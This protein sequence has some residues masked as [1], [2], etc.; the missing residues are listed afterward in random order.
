MPQIRERTEISDLRDLRQ[1][2]EEVR[3]SG[4]PRLLVVGADEIAMLVPV[5]S[6]ATSDDGTTRSK[7]DEDRDVQ[8]FLSAAGSWKGHPPASEEPA[9]GEIP[10]E[11]LRAYQDAFGS[12][13][14]HVDPE[15]F[16]AQIKAARGSHRP[17]VK[18]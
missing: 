14:G 1:L 12:W 13:K 15:A 18:L 4:T 6:T 2:A 11:K 3:A 8:E 10:P 17:A 16:K 7:E 9:T 5:R